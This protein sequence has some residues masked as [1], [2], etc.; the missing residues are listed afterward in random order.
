MNEGVPFPRTGTSFVGASS[1]FADM[2]VS[3]PFLLPFDA[4]QVPLGGSLAGGL[5]AVGAS[6]L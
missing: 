5:G 3:Q 2:S 6:C 4:A 1:P